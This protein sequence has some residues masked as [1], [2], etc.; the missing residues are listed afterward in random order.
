MARSL[1][2]V[3]GLENVLKNLDREAKKIKR[4][5]LKGV[6]KAGLLVRREAVKKAPI[7][8]GNLRSSAFVAW[9]GGQS[10]NPSFRGEEGGADAAKLSR[11]HAT[12]IA[13]SKGQTFTIL[14]DRPRAV[15]GFS[16]AYALFVHEDGVQRRFK[17][18]KFLEKAVNENRTQILSLIAKESRFK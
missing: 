11:D 10:S 14:T 18:F 7:D 6:I 13:E 3:K 17:G 4:L 16:A 1:I 8:L 15:V 5:S 9:K 12:V 2:R